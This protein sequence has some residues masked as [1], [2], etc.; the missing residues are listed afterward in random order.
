[1]VAKRLR[2]EGLHAS[3][4]GLAKFY[5]CYEETGSTARHLGSGTLSKLTSDV[6]QIVEEQMQRDGDH[7]GAAYVSAG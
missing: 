7:G 1:M 3:R 4:Q 5:H 6:L 2:E